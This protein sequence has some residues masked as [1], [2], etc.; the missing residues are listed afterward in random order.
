MYKPI[1]ERQKDW[2]S[3][4]KSNGYES[5][6]TTVIGPDGRYVEVQI[7]SERMDEIAERGFAAHWKYKGVNGF[8][9]KA[10]IF[11]DWLKSI[12]E[13]LENAQGNAVEFLADVQST[14]FVDNAV[15]AFT[16]KGDLKVLPK[17]ATALDFAFAV[18]SNVGCTCQVV[19]INGV[20]Q[21]FYYKLQNG[22]QV[23]II[24]NR[25]QKPAES[26]LQTVVTHRAQARIRSALNDIKRAEAAEGKDILARKLQNTYKVSI[27]DNVD[28]LAKWYGFPNRLEFLSAVSSKQID[29]KLLKRFRAEGLFLVLNDPAPRRDVEKRPSEVPQTE[30]KK[31]TIVQGIIIN[32]QPGTMFKYTLA[33]CCKPIQGE[34]IFAFLANDPEEGAKIHSDICPNAKFLKSNFDFKVQKATWGNTVRSDYISDIIVNGT[35]KGRGVIRELSDCIAQI[36][37]NI[38]SFS[39]SGSGGYF[40]GEISLQVSHEDQVTQAIMAI[41]KFDFVQNVRRVEPA[42][43]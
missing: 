6:H 2:I 10:N 37:I 19:K 12:R 27:E 28:M 22:D 8:A 5:L 21:P 20:M 43:E 17:G 33:S 32:D 38:K 18:H 42:A 7:R 40:E 14:I 29:L 16:P 41:K 31:K 35:D 39:I 26:W 9:S 25:N 34:P 11:D 4:P 15:H 30:K 24:T 3:M 36:G 13:G 1:P 23:E